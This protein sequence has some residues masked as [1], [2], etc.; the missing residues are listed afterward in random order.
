VVE[1]PSGL[2]TTAV[3]N[4]ILLFPGDEGVHEAELW[5]SDGTASGTRLVRDLWVGGS[6]YPGEL[7]VAGGQLYFNA[8]DGV[9]GRELWKS[10]GRAEGTRLVADLNGT[11]GSFP[12]RLTTSG[13]RLF[14]VADDGT[15]SGLWI[16]DLL[17][18][19]TSFYTVTPCRLADTRNPPGPSGGPALGAQAIRTFP[20]T[21]GACGVPS[22]AV[23]VS[24]NLAAVEAAAA[25]YLTLFGSGAPGPP[26]V[27]TVNFSS[28]QTRANNAVVPLATDGTGTVRV[29]NGSAGAVHFVLDVNGYFR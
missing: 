1:R 13:D 27:S 12:S 15:G 14:F 8:E 23:A 9:L 4:G 10:D 20:V 25:G 19:A 5:R 11:G 24:V 7:T 22:T 29:K 26:L 6:G 17:P 21:G 3:L 16:L 28:G 18:P 2:T